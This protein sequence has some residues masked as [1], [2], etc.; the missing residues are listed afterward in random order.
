MPVHERWESK[1]PKY[2]SDFK[3]SWVKP[4]EICDKV[5]LNNNKYI[6]S[7]LLEETRC[8]H[9]NS[10]DQLRYNEH[11]L[12]GRRKTEKNDGQTS[13]RIWIR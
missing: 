13:I 11:L 6:I 4:S 5:L 1:N 7:Q 3:F 12:G 2:S 8:K 10:F 9:N